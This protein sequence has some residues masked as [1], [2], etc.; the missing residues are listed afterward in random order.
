MSDSPL[1]D[2]L[3]GVIPSNPVRP[4]RREREQGQNRRRLP[5]A[6]PHPHRDAPLPDGNRIHIDEYARS[7]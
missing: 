3:R 4:V 2:P 7:H 5:V 6:P 1:L